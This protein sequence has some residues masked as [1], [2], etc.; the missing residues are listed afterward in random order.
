MFQ[1]DFK[2]FPKLE[3]IN[4]NGE[5]HY[6]TPEGEL[7]ISITT[8]LSRCKEKKKSIEKWKK[9]VGETKANQISNSAKNSGNTMHDLVENFLLNKEIDVSNS[10][11]NGLYLFN[12]VKPFLEDNISHIFAL[13]TQLYSNTLKLAGTVDCIALWKG[14]PAIIDFKTSRKY[15]KESYIMD[16]YLQATAYSLMYE[17]LTGIPIRDIVVLISTNHN[18]V[19]VFER[20]RKEFFVELKRK[21]QLHHDAFKVKEKKTVF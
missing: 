20:K 4:V 18:N 16:Y 12:Q 8:L 21:L 13:E 11:P 19:Q 17:E 1:H 9:K 15:K 5:R 7:C 6:K 14:K 2:K 3:R 10:H